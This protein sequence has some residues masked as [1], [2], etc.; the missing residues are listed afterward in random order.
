MYAISPW[1]STKKVWQWPMQQEKLTEN[2]EEEEEKEEEE[3]GFENQNDHID[4]VKEI[5][6]FFGYEKERPK[7]DVEVSKWWKA[8]ASQD[9]FDETEWMELLS[10]PQQQQIDL[11]SLS[12]STVN[13]TSNIISPEVIL[14]PNLYHLLQTRD[15][16]QPDKYLLNFKHKVSKKTMRIVSE[17]WYQMELNTQQ[18]LSHIEFQKSKKNQKTRQEKA[19]QTIQKHFRG[20]QGRKKAKEIRAEY[21]VLVKG[22]AIR[23]GKCEECG[24]ASAVLECRECIESTVPQSQSQSTPKEQNAALHFCPNCWVHVHST[25]RRKNHVAYPMTTSAFAPAP[26]QSNGLIERMSCTGRSFSF[27]A[28]R[29]EEADTADSNEKP[30]EQMS[31][32]LRINADIAVPFDDEKKPSPSK[33]QLLFNNKEPTPEKPERSSSPQLQKPKELHE[34]AKEVPSTALIPR[35]QQREKRAMTVRIASPKSTTASASPRRQTSPNSSNAII[36]AKNPLH[37]EGER[38]LQEEREE[39][40][41]RMIQKARRLSRQKQKTCSSSN[42]SA[43]GSSA[44]SEKIPSCSLD[45]ETAATKI[46][47]AR[48][49]SV[50]RRNEAPSATSATG[51]VSNV[52]STSTQPIE[53][54]NGSPKKGVSLNMDRDTAAKIIQRARRNSLSRRTK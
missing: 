50:S 18:K 45:Q 40:A 12:S 27:R 9:A 35:L 54:P 51:S 25:R 41:A 22:R 43:S 7:D 11:S 4:N 31:S 30:T 20:L 3:D 46:Q 38:L 42:S 23:K 14:S 32:S 21:F 53:K 8:H 48:R 15:Q 13:K 36:A 10:L 49:L 19:A 34:P 47:R 5:R 39:K 26:P 37:R 28:S 29:L 17:T 1:N 24:D 6:E 33:F 52:S 44:P 16:F 2:P